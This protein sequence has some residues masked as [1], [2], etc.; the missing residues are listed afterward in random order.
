M[1]GSSHAGHLGSPQD[2][3]L[4]GTLQAPRATMEVVK[5]DKTKEV[6]PN[7]EH[8]KWMAQDQQLLSSLHS[9]MIS[10]VLLVPFRIM[11]PE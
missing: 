4:D 6:V 11:Q 9:G 7:P 2:W 5:D 3:I 1:E 10:V 8:A